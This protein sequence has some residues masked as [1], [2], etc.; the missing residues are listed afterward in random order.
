MVEFAAHVCVRV[1]IGKVNLWRQFDAVFA[2]EAND[3]RQTDCGSG[4]AGIGDPLR[5]MAGSLK[6]G[7]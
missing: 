7:Q 6:V 4:V 1:V 3:L 5:L 2:D